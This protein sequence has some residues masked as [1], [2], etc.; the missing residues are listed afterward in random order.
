MN[1]KKYRLFKFMAL[2]MA[3]VWLFG[4]YATG[5]RGV[6]AT[7]DINNPGE[8]DNY[9]IG[10]ENLGENDEGGDDE[11]DDL[12]TSAAF[13]AR[14]TV[15][16]ALGLRRRD[17]VADGIHQYPF[18][19]NLFEQTRP[20]HTNIG[21]FQG[22]P[23]L[24]NLHEFFRDW[25][26][27]NVNYTSR[28]PLQADAE[29][30]FRVWHAISASPAASTPG[31]HY[32][33]LP[34][35]SD[36][37]LSE[38]LNAQG[39]PRGYFQYAFVQ[40]LE[41]NTNFNMQG[42]Q[43]PLGE[44]Y[45]RYVIMGSHYDRMFVHYYRAG[46]LGVPT[47]F[48]TL[49]NHLFPVSPVC[50]VT[51]TH[52][53]PEYATLLADLEPIRRDLI[54]P[55]GKIFGGWFDTLGQAQNLGSQEGRVS[56]RCAVMGRVTTDPNRTIFARWYPLPT[57]E[58]AVTP[59]QLTQQQVADGATL[60]YTITITTGTLPANLI[61]LIVEDL[62]DSRLSLVD[63]S[64]AISPLPGSYPRYTLAED[65]TL[66]FYISELS[67]SDPI[68]NG[69]VVINFRATV[70]ED[71]IPPGT[72]TVVEIPNT[73]ILLRPPP[74]GEN[75][76]EER[77]DESDEIIV[78]VTPPVIPPEG[79]PPVICECPECECPCDCPVCECECD[80]VEVQQ[81]PGNVPPPAGKAPT[82]GDFTATAPLLAGLL[83]SMSAVL[84][85]TSLRK[86]FRR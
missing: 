80:C 2:F 74:P 68:P 76:E 26:V 28:P 45:Y 6:H 15:T 43:S 38:R 81:Q 31:W 46:Y 21:T 85:G 72:T 59:G 67:G 52:S 35:G 56:E 40:R 25:A 3:F 29:A 10:G 55:E 60:A 84:G 63:R 37:S 11:G 83:F 75:G 61:N 9:Y 77:I 1:L 4:A 5:M 44:S 18:N 48:Q 20:Y 65:G 78:R 32:L 47:N 70:N 58:K 27:E 16:W 79:P 66:R 33:M 8:D 36:D 22:D 14:S 54:H 57:V 62:L 82:T 17:W 24:G 39:Q 34:Y 19:D 69:R 41:F 42:A 13:N 51:L 53:N 86:R 30:A 23:T 7:D 50:I 73:A 12:W 49:R 64:V 71:A